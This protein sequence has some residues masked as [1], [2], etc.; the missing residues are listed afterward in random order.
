L[1]QAPAALHSR[2]LLPEQSRS[3]GRHEPLHTPLPE[4]TKLHAVSVIQAPAALHSRGL[5]PEQSRLPGKHEPLHTPS[6][7]QT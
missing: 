3:P 6:P 5:L 4:Q 2:G 7:L 1:T